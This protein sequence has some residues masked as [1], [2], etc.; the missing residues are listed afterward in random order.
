MGRKKTG[1]RTVAMPRRSRTRTPLPQASR[2]LEAKAARTALQAEQTAH[3]R[4]KRRAKQSGG[5]H[6]HTKH[7]RG[8]SILAPPRQRVNVRRRKPQQAH[9]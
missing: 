5:K 8:L 7:L 9:A 6:P 3:N 2:W 1:S 4:K